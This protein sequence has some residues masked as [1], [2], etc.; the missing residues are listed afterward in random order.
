MDSNKKS[1]LWITINRACLTWMCNVIKRHGR[2][3]N[4]DNVF[5]RAYNR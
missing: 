1:Y 5:L 2:E 4:E 3:N